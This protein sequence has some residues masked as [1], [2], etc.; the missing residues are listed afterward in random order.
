MNSAR[1]LKSFP[2]H[3][4]LVHS[5]APFRGGD[6]NSS[7][8]VCH[9]PISSVNHDAIAAAVAAANQDDDDLDLSL[10]KALTLR[11]LDSAKSFTERTTGAAATA[12][13]P[14]A[15]TA[16][17]AT[18]VAAPAAYS[19]DN[20]LSNYQPYAR[21]KNMTTST[22]RWV[23][24]PTSFGGTHRDADHQNHDDA[25]PMSPKS[26]IKSPIFAFL[27][28]SR[29]GDLVSAAPASPGRASET[30]QLGR[31]AASPRF[32]EA[33]GRGVVPQIDAPVSASNSAERVRARYLNP[34]LTPSPL[35]PPPRP[36]VHLTQVLASPYCCHTNVYP[37]A[38]CSALLSGA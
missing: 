15:T 23:D 14:T 27:S 26:K 6:E 3:L 19:T 31:P 1:G 35:L 24:A 13:T 2:H 21:P 25:A 30:P 38:L 36:C 34:R 16:T 9:S 32:I 37:F 12:T 18:I 22:T 4:D 8:V 10:R 29:K 28:R 11:T 7:D 20:L 33:G 17:K 5:P